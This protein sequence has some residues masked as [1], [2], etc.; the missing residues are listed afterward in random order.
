M[1]DP[2]DG[3]KPLIN[4]GSFVDYALVNEVSR[5]VDGYRLSTFLFKEKDSNGGRIHLGPVWDFNLGFGN[6]N[7]CQGDLTSGFAWNFHQ[8]CPGGEWNTPFW[9]PRFLADP[10]F[11]E[12]MRCRWEE[13]RAGPYH[14][15]TL[16]ASIDSYVELLDGAQQRNFNRWPILDESVWPN[17]IVTGSFQNEINYLKSYLSLRLEWLD[18][19]IPGE[20]ISPIGI[21]EPRINHLSYPNPVAEKIYWEIETTG[22]SQLAI[23]SSDGKKVH[24]S[25]QTGASFSW[26]LE[27]KNGQRVSTGI[28]YY[29][30]YQEGQLQHIGKIVVN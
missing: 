7:Y 14:T 9:W 27:N 21:I 1:Q 6:A 10:E 30:L 20:C 28:Y 16:M 12:Q 4:M 29:H 3:Y 11:V 22:S 25:D 24:Y 2:F 26:N 8:Y 5:N 13:L 17:P 23:Y 15:D 18:N 19:E